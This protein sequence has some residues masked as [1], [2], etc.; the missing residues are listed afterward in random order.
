[1]PR[2][3]DNTRYVFPK[4]KNHTTRRTSLKPQPKS[5]EANMINEVKMLISKYTRV[6]NKLETLGINVNG[7]IRQAKGH[8]ISRT[9][10]IRQVWV[11]KR[12]ITSTYV[13]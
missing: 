12:T 1:M 9:L 3:W 8:E 13:D 11:P 6:F 2:Y 10:K 4:Y 7:T 5:W